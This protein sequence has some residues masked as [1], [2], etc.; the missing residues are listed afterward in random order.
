MQYCLF[1]YGTLMDLEI[2]EILFGKTFPIKPAVLED[3][4]ICHH[5]DFDYFFLR[6]APGAKTQGGYVEIGEQE[7]RKIDLWEGRE[8]YE[9]TTVKIQTKH[10]VQFAQAYIGLMDGKPLPE[11]YIGKYS[12]RTRKMQ[13][14]DLMEWRKEQKKIQP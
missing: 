3:Y 6:P 8:E 11:K 7:L 5:D 1:I 2:H 14:L 12:K 10:G 13:Q 4:M 9:R